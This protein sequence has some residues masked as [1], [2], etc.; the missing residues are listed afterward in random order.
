MNQTHVVPKNST[1][2]RNMP[3]GLRALRAGLRGASLVA[4]QAVERFAA[5]MFFRPSR[6]AKIAPP[7]VAGRAARAFTVTSGGEQLAVYGWGDGPLVLLVHGWQGHAGQLS[8]FVEP[9][10]QRGYRVVTFDMP[11]HGG[12]SGSR[13]SVLDMALAVTDVANDCAPLL[14]LK[15]SPPVHAIIAHSLGAT[16]TSIAI[17]RGVAPRSAVLLAPAAEPGYFARRAGAMMGLSRPRV[18]GMVRNIEEALGGDVE[19]IDLRVLS[20]GMSTPALVMHDPDDREVPFEHGASIARAWPAARLERLSGLGHQ[21]LLRDPVVIA[22]A[23]EFV[24]GGAIAAS[25]Y[26]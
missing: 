10:V 13:A 15:S 20:R 24:D 12:S 2:V 14:G 11:G 18:E 1:I 5:S 17:A 4:P 19:A 6:S 16:A 23:V 21:R 9:L 8:G 7:R 3:I 26:H 22:R 25:S